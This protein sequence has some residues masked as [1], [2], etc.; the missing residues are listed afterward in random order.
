MFEEYILPELL[1]LVPVLYIVGA[2]LKKS[3]TV[4]DK[5]IPFV[6]GAFGVILA[7]L[8]EGSVVGWSVESVYIAIVQGILCAGASVYG[9]QIVK[10]IFKDE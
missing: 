8:Y 9:N 7:M 10:Q 2:G 6:I 4:K 5:Y 3:E 1:V